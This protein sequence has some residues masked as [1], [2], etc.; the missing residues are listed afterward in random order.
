MGEEIFLQTAVAQ[1]VQTTIALQSNPSGGLRIAT[2]GGVFHVRW[3]ENAS[4]SALG[5]LAFLPNF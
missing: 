4:A 1:A 2:P 3:D 5:Q